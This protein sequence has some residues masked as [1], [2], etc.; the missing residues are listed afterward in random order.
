MEIMIYK[1]DEKNHHDFQKN[2]D[3]YYK[4]KNM[5]LFNFNYLY[6]I[7]KTAYKTFLKIIESRITENKEYLIIGTKNYIFQN[8][9]HSQQLQKTW[10][11]I[12]PFHAL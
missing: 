5:V 7:D 6:R 4:D 10:E 1:L 2:Y 11:N 8:F 12:V 9:I 3:T